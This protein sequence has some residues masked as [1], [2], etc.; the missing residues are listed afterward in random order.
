MALSYG[1]SGPI[2]GSRGTPP[3]P[4]VRST[5]TSYYF[6]VTMTPASNQSAIPA[7]RLYYMPFCLPQITVDRILIEVTTG[8]A[9]SARLGLYTNLNGMPDQLI[10]DAG[11]VDTSA[12]GIIEASFS[13]IALP[14]WCWVAVVLNAAATLRISAS[15]NN[16]WLLGIANLASSAKGLEAAFTYGAL[17]TTAP[18][19]TVFSTGCPT[20]CLRKS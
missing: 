6:P 16:G 8:L 3:H 10:V 20:V 18:A 9:G 7:N 13:P 4:G 12:V 19:P 1:M 17:P 2:T 15:N 5:P 14:G 11:A